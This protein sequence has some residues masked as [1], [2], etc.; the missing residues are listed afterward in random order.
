[1]IFLNTLSRKTIKKYN[2]RTG[3]KEKIRRKLLNQMF[4]KERERRQ[5][6]RI[7]GKTEELIRHKRKCTYGTQ[8]KMKQIRS[9]SRNLEKRYVY[10]CQE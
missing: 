5:Y 9:V 4:N 10:D 2:K 6:N 3:E 8:M 1:M 7:I